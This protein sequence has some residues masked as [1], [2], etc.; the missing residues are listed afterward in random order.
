V[1][2]AVERITSEAVVHVFTLIGQSNM[3][4]RA[5]WDSGTEMPVGTLQWDS[6]GTLVAATRTLDHLQTPDLRTFSLAVQF[7]IGYK[8][9]HPNVVIAFVPRA[10][11][12][13]VFNDGEW[14]VGGPNYNEVVN[15]TNA[16][17]TATK[18]NES[19]SFG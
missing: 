16:L 13:T 17:V 14:S 4:D 7:A 6:I 9:A 15:A 2:Y 18:D 11:G 8:V 3:R 10:E 19:H 5:T 1:F 12:G